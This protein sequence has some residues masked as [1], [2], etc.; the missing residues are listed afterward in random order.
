MTAN[1]SLK[2]SLQFKELVRTDLSRVFQEQMPVE[3]I[4]EW[5]KKEMPKSRECIFTP[6]N[7]IFTMLLSALQEDKSIQNGLNIFKKVFESR[8][9]ELLQTETA[10]LEAEKQADALNPIKAGRP[11]KYKSK[12]LKSHQQTISDNTAA[13]ST[14][15]KRLDKRAFQIAFEHS[16][17]FG[18]CEIESS[19]GMQTFLTDG[20]CLQLQDT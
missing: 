1:E 4:E 13:Y 11:K 6:A 2:L 12:L 7:V 5:V 14:A 10:L 20:A 8:S 17:D 15:R 19:H 9:N 18:K 3:L 16:T